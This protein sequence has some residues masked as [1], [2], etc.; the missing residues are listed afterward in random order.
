MKKKNYRGVQC[1]KQ[2]FRK[3]DEVCRTY[4]KIQ[5]ALVALL[6]EDTGVVSF[7]C[8]VQ[9][10]G[11]EDDQYTSDVVAIKSDGT[12]MVRECVWRK[13][14]SR[15]STARLLDVSRNYWLSQGVEDWEIVIEKEGSANNESE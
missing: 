9:L 12:T 2:S 6:Q 11:V 1:I 3:C 8:N 5:T 4:S 13:N 15:P 7:K 10:V 14:L